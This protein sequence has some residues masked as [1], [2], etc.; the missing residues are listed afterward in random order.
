MLVA[1]AAL[2]WGGAATVGKAVFN[3]ALARL[4]SGPAGIDPLI[5]AQ[6][7]T[8]FSLLLLAPFL[9]WL[10]GR[11]GVRVSRSELLQCC[12]VGVLGVAGSNFFYYFA[13]EKSTVATAIVVQYT[14]PVWV[15]LYMVLTRRDRAV[16]LRV[17]AVLLAV[18]GSAAVVVFAPGA[19]LSSAT[20]GIVAAL[21]AAFSYSIY[22]V[23]A[24]GVVKRMGS[25]AVMLY[26]LLSASV[27]WLIVN[28]PWKIAAQHYT[29]SQ[30]VFLLLFAM[31]SMLLPYTLYFTGLKYLDPTRAIVTSC[32][33][34]VFAIVFA[35]MFVGEAV[36]PLQVFGMA[37]VLSATVLI[38]R[39][40]Q[41]ALAV[42]HT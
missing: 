36:A 40:P 20:L 8:S 26:A 4:V 12:V 41:E 13:I 21:G 34:P 9:L 15:F 38:Q 27:F 23:G 14:A 31:G 42:E 10:R 11:D 17:V 2:C 22:N 29:R 37:L 3:G 19:R 28:P 35:A 18:A 30:W 32:L 24:A 25:L 6:S 16:P 5:L 39:R 33:E 7:R 1:G